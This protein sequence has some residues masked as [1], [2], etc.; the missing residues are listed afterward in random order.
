MVWNQTVKMDKIDKRV[1]P[2]Q[3]I[4]TGVSEIRWPDQPD[5]PG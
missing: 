4:S 5:Q 1:R 3:T 2:L